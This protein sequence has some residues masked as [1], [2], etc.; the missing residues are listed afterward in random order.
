[1]GPRPQGP[2]ES[3]HWADDVNSYL[4]GYEMICMHWPHFCMGFPEL[5][6]R[7]TSIWKLI[8]QILLLPLSHSLISVVAGSQVHDW[9]HQLQLGIS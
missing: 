8:Y 5:A 3:L 7:K 1:M 9:Q 4:T 2:G 6:R